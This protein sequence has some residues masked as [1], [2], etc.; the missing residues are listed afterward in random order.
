MVSLY[1]AAIL[2][3]EQVQFEK[4]IHIMHVAIETECI[5]SHT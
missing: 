5:V 2:L 1:N 4:Q 3:Y